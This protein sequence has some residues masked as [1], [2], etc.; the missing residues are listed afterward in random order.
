MWLNPYREVESRLILDVKLNKIHDE[1][2]L[3]Q[4]EKLR[5]LDELLAREEG[6]LKRLDTT[7]FR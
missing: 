2:K 7:D 3:G 1:S 4:T 5:I 6:T